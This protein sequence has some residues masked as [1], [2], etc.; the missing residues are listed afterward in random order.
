M[1]IG[2]SKDT[3]DCRH[4]IDCEYL[5]GYGY[6]YRCYAQTSWCGPGGIKETICQNKPLPRW[7]PKWCPH[8]ERRATLDKGSNG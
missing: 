3:I 8:R 6:E 5:T 4:C 2:S 7:S 1:P